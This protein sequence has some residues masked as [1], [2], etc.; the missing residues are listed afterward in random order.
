MAPLGVNNVIALSDQK[1]LDEVMTSSN[2][3]PV[4]SAVLVFKGIGPDNAE[5]TSI[6]VSFVSSRLP[7]DVKLTYQERL[8]TEPEEP[9]NESQFPEMNTVLPIMAMLQ[10]KHLERQAQRFNYT[11]PLPEVTMCRFPYPPYFEFHDMKTYALVLTRFCV[12]ML[13]PF[14]V[15]V[16]RLTIEKASGM[17]EYLRMAGLNDWIYWISHYLSGGFMHLIIVTLMMLFLCIKHNDQGRAFIQYSDPLLLFWI[18]MCFCSSCLMHATLLS[19]FFESP[20]SAVAGALLYWTFSCVMPFLT[21][22]HASGRG[23]QYIARRHKLATAIFPGM[24]LHWSFRVLERF[25]K[26]VE[27]GANWGNFY[28]RAVTPDNLT[29]AEIVFVGFLCDCVIVALVW[30]MDNVI[31]MG[32]GVPKSYFYPFKARYWIPRMTFAPPQQ[33]TP[34]QI[35]N[36]E[37]EPRDLPVAIS[38]VQASKDYDGL[39]AA[40]NVSVRIFESEITV[41][42]GHNGA[43]KTTL[44]NMIT[45]FT[46]CSSGQVI[47]GGYDMSL[48]TREARHSI[49][50]CPQNNIF[51]QDLTIEEHLVFFAVLKGAPR[52]NVRLIVVTLLND[53]GLMPF[54]STKPSDLSLG[55]LR[56]LCTALAIVAGPRL[57]VL[58]EPTANMDP[59]GRREMWELLL[60]IRRHCSILVTTQDLDEADVL[61]DRVFIMAQGRIRCGGSPTF[62]KQRFG[63]GYHMRI[64]KARRCN[65]L[66]IL[67]LLA[68]YSPSARLESDSDNEAIFN[69][70]HLE[71]SKSIV[72]MFKDIEQR[73]ADL[74]IDS[75]GLNVTSLEDV[76]IHVGEDQHLHR[77][78]DQLSPVRPSQSAKSLE[79]NPARDDGGIEARSDAVRVMANA[80][81][82][83]AGCLARV[84]VLLAKR[85]TCS[86]RERKMPLFSWLL[87]LVLLVL[88]FELEHIALKGSGR[89]QERLTDTLYYNF[90]DVVVY[91]QG[92]LQTDNFN[93]PF[94]EKHLVPMLP[95]LSFFI[96]KFP[97]DVDV[98]KGLLEYARE[99]LWNYVFH[100]HFGIQMTEKTG[101][102]LWYNGQ[103]Q[104]T[105]LLVMTL[106]NNARLRNATGLESAQFSVDVTVPA[107]G[108]SAAGET[109]TGRDS[110]LTYREVL[111][112]VLRSIFFPLV[113]SL[114]CSNFVLLPVAER[115][116][117]VKQ[118][119]LVSGVGPLMYWGTA[120]LGDFL[121]YTGTALFVLA[122]ILYFERELAVD[123]IQSILVLNV[124]HGYAALPFI[125]MASFLFESPVF[126][127]STL[128]ICSFLLSSCGCFLAV[129]MEHASD[130]GSLVTL[131]VEIALELLRLIPSYSY[132]RG[133]TKILQLGAENT[134]CRRG[135]AQLVSICHTKAIKFKLSLQRCCQ[136]TEASRMITPYEVHPYSAF[137][138]L[139]T[140]SVEGAVLFVVLLL[141]EGNWTRRLE[142]HRTEPE[143]S[144]VQ[145]NSPNAAL[146]P[147]A[148]GRKVAGEVVDH[149]VAAE[150]E[151]VA[152]FSYGMKRFVP[153]GAPPRMAMLVY[154]LFRAYGFGGHNRVLKG[155]SF[156]LRAG[157]CFALLG[158]NGAGKTTTFRILT[159]ELLPHNGDAFIDGFSVVRNTRDFQRYLGY[160]P[161]RD[162]LLDMMTGEETLILFARLR[163]ITVTREY[164]E[165]VLSIFRL[166]D[167]S[168]RLVGTYR[169][170]YFVD[171]HFR[172]RQLNVFDSRW[173]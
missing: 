136:R 156:G 77:R 131:L 53:V 66:G 17:K 86:W 78:S 167:I 62:L 101:N 113:S 88:L 145:P 36:F 34:H 1:Q 140:L 163:G 47:L 119:Q 6:T 7:L 146:K 115:A 61:G 111:P 48:C 152:A 129:F 10:Q 144:F 20:Q 71:S 104:H 170:A 122:P 92:F 139:L 33:R 124:L 76:L 169:V 102:V 99:S 117:Q 160:C 121:F 105:A 23:Y 151:L 74:G 154:R 70:G 134:L 45:G 147:V 50:Y 116:M 56:R 30:Y 3:T 97:T 127:F 123:E 8:I 132:S 162:G 24:S 79:P 150:E 98:N 155:L 100:L 89:S 91:A 126:G 16:A 112:K 57:V 67:Q 54:R 143:S 35:A 93:E 153:V 109:E 158:V 107:T 114:M 165:V 108:P 138:E 161:Q 157:E 32:P 81:M 12:G 26:F 29:L 68:K 43:G 172:P 82:T 21:L 87:P 40:C 168:D 90:D 110:Q 15:Y 49:G 137:Y 19:M 142:R 55:Q 75:V 9:I 65:L 64:M 103:I 164:L 42:L 130:G 166:S 44:L 159:G 14:A 95:K 25:E 118:L 22:E 13:V 135:G 83:D 46:G 94:Y 69:L 171:H 173:L 18:L 37:E 148:R 106:F 80:S 125:Y 5:P 84:W 38:V 41:L 58:D 85:A 51:F 31:P 2:Q 120:F 72:T 59:D 4:D 149:D 96:R 73:S 128:A 28:D 63:T 141:L 11:G 60:K 52:S 133:M 39:L 27:N